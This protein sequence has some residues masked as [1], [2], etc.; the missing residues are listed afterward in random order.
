MLLYDR[1]SQSERRTGLEV[2]HLL[3]FSDVLIVRNWLPNIGFP[4][5]APSNTSKAAYAWAA[6]PRKRSKPIRRPHRPAKGQSP[7]II[8]AANSQ[9]ET[10]D[11]PLCILF[12]PSNELRRHD[13]FFATKGIEDRQKPFQY[14][15]H[16]NNLP[17]FCQGFISQDCQV[18]CRNFGDTKCVRARPKKLYVRRIFAGCSTPPHDQPQPHRN[19]RRGD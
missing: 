19:Q 9:S 17:V 1:T 5:V 10:L 8:P 2:E 13:W 4:G 15:V 6:T 16:R 3:V 11:L 18:C 7:S 12:A 14:L